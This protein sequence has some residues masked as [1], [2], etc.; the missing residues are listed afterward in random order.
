MGSAIVWLVNTIISLLIF[1]IFARAIV[2]WL[3][4]FDILNTRNR[5]VYQVLTMLERITDPVLR[6]FQRIVPTLG[7]VDISPIVAWLALS[8]IR[9]IFNA[10]ATPILLTLG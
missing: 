2:S 10:Y 4:A 3:V 9:I 8:V 6:P 1:L 7:G 5:F